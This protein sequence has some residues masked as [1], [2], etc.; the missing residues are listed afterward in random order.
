MSALLS[1]CINMNSEAPEILQQQDEAKKVNIKTNLHILEHKW[2]I[3]PMD[4]IIW[5]KTIKLSFT[6]TSLRKV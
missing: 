4:L 6:F 5:N 3:I 1:L 2:E